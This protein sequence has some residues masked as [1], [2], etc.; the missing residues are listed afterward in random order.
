[1]YKNILNKINEYENITIFRHIHPDGDAMF[2]AYGLYLF[3]KDNFKNKKIK[4]S[5]F[6]TYDKFNIIDKVSDNFIN[7]SLGIVLDTSN[8]YRID[9]QRALNCK[10]LIKIDHHPIVDQY[11][12]INYV[13]DHSAACSEVLA[14][15]FLSKE[16]SKYK[17]SKKVCEA[18]YCGILTDTMNFK[19]S[20]CTPD[21]LLISSSLA[22]KGELKMSD[23]SVMLF[24][25][26]LQDFKLDAKLRTLLQIK[27]KFGYI[28]LTKK[29]LNKLN[30]DSEKVKSHVEC[31]GSIS[32][33]NIWAMIAYNKDSDLFD[34]SIRA[35]S[36]YSVNK[37]AA[38]YNGGGHRC[39]AGIRSL[40]IQQ[41]NELIDKLANISK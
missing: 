14:R 6:D 20:S 21:T 12:N 34:M 39:A 2:S 24:N 37:L 31:I 29:D 33:L 16:L 28:L 32:D 10:Y 18:L 35:K 22:R 25:D 36:K 15:M 38:K 7:N 40:N 11:G 26:S 30:A 3:L 5:G 4:V 27:D 17:V 19:T 13:E 8:K 1:M 41:V 9:D 23:L